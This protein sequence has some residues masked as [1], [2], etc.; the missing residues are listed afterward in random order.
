MK[1]I[2][3]FAF[4]GIALA[5][6]ASCTYEGDK[7]YTTVYKDAEEESTDFITEGLPYRNGSDTVTEVVYVRFYG[8]NRYVPYVAVSYFLEKFANF[9]LQS[10][11]YAGGKYKYQNKVNGK[12]FPLTIDISA[13]TIYCPEW[14]GFL[15]K[16]SPEAKASESF[17]IKFLK[18]VETFTGQASQTFDLA[19]YGMKIYGGIDDAY[20]PLC[21][22][23]QLF[24]CTDYNRYVYNGEG[25]YYIDPYGDYKY[26]SFKKSPW[27]MNQDGSVAVR[28][29]QLISFSYN[30]MC[31]TH[32][33]LYGQ[34]GY[35]GFA[36]S[37]SGYADQSVVATADKLSFDALLQQYDGETRDLLLS[38]SY[39]DYLKGLARLTYY[40]YGDLHSAIHTR[41][42]KPPFTSA[43]NEELK[44]FAVETES[45]KWSKFDAL[46]EDLEDIRIEK[47]KADS[48]ELSVP[49]EVLPDG[50]TAVIRFDEFTFDESSWQA[51]YAQENLEP[52]PDPA[53][54]T[55]PDDTMGF[56]YKCFYTILNDSAYS[57]VKNVLID[58]S[59]NTG[60]INVANQKILGYLLGNGDMRLYDV[61]TGTMY[62][63]YTQGDL[64][65]DGYIDEADT[66]Y[67]QRLVSTTYTDA[68]GEEKTDGRGL[69]FAVL[70]SFISF[71]NGNAF[72]C[73][74]YDNG[75]PIIGERSGGGSCVVGMA[76]TAD[77][78]PFQYSSSLRW[79]H[80]DGTSVESG[81]PI[82]KALT[83][84]QFY[85]DTALQNVM[86]ELFD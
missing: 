67:H 83:Y 84:E 34:P 48:F 23:N 4:L 12:N 80:P 57:N 76:A 82:T 68:Y 46:S 65:L 15:A 61:H 3:R 43:Q 59:C 44:N 63:L 2:C 27:Y 56:F 51:Y 13:D 9:D 79:S 10:T 50:K 8:G 72:L 52:E 35:Y 41:N 31:F 33:Y 58:L 81:A 77:G 29:T 25:I 28:P 78:I 37:G 6:F 21:V 70:T 7:I 71:S 74:C 5:F 11:S 54:V 32:D 30:F 86:E 18:T 62:H 20:V 38:S 53:T 47:G 40:T 19:K 39:L 42:F 85:D 45:S 49:L 24:A 60:G 14:I 17:L 26:A 55:I 16:T 64:N 36:D 69:N 1:N 75:I 73:I 66:G 22:L